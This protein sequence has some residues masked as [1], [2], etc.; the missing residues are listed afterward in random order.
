MQLQFT[1]NEAEGFRVWLRFLSNTLI[2]N[3]Y[4]P[5]SSEARGNNYSIT[6]CEA[7]PGSVATSSLNSNTFSL[8]PFL[9]I[10]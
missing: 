2:F 7:P 3:V 9:T 8:D 1:V 5:G 10:S 4:F 6:F